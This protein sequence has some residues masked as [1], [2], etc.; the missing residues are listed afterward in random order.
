MS[1]LLTLSTVT[2][3]AS[4][5]AARARAMYSRPRAWIVLSLSSSCAR[6]GASPLPRNLL[7]CLAP[8]LCS[9]IS[10]RLS[11]LSSGAAVR[12]KLQT[13]VMTSIPPSSVPGT[14]CC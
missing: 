3:S 9:P 13:T 7:S 4:S 2:G 12:I 1:L 6:W 10:L 14:A 11:A 5:P 8:S